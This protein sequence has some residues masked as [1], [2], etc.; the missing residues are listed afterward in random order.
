MSDIALLKISG[1]AFPYLHLG[2][3]DDAIIGEWAIAFGNPFGLF[4]V[5][6]RPTVTVG[7][8]SATGMNLQ[9]QE[10]RVYKGML[11]TDAAINSGNSGGPLVN[12]VGE[13]IGVN[14]VIY[15]PNQGSIGLGFAIPINRAKGII[16]QLKKSGKIERGFWTGMEVQTIDRRLARVFGLERAQGV[17]VSDVQQGSPADRA[18][19]APGDII[20][21][22]NGESV[23][24]EAS[25]AAIFQD[26]KVGDALGLKVTRNRKVVDLTLKLEKR[27]E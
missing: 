19:F 24:D 17:I 27:P 21:S 3:S 13:V 26:A 14:A 20:T 18:G 8:I 15:T 12:T 10:G 9:E 5:N 25:L 6:N 2:N 1:K 22:V 4:D 23:T 7:V 16:A 11:Q